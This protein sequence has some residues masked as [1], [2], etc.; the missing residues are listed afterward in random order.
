M[1]N[2]TFSR[3][4][5]SLHLKILAG[6]VILGMLI[7]GLV[8]AVWYEKRVFEEAEAEERSLL[9]QREA[10]GEAYRGLIAL[11]LDTD[12]AMLWDDS[13]M[14]AY[15]SRD[16]HTM[17]VMD[18]LKGYY[19]EPCQTARIDTI[20]R[21]LHEKRRL[22]GRMVELPSTAS[23]MDSLLAR[24]LPELERTASAQATTVTERTEPEKE[25]KQGG[26]LGLFRRKKKEAPTRTTTRVLT[27]PNT[28]HIAEMRRFED[29][30][31]TALEEQRQAY[32]RLSDSLEMRNRILTRN[33]SRLISEIGKEE[34]ERMERRHARVAELRE[35]AFALICAISAAG[36][37]CAVLL[38]AVV[39]RDIR[40]RTSERKQREGL[41][42]T[43]RRSIRENEELIRSRQRIMQ[44]VTHDL[45]SPLTAIRGNAELIL[46]EGG[47]CAA[48]RHA[49]H[50]RQSAERMGGLMEN[51]MEYYRI[52]NGKE[53]AKAKPFRLAGIAE[54]LE[55]EFEPRM[56]AKRLVFGVHCTADEVVTGDR[57]MILRI[58]SNLLSNALKFTRRG[59]VSLTT[60]YRE[61]RFT[62]TVDDTGTGIEKDRQEQIFKPFER[63]G[64]AATQDGFGLGL[65]IV[66][67]LTELMEGS[68]TVDS[69]PG[70]GSRFS[71][72][73]P[74]PLSEGTE[75]HDHAAPIAYGKL[76]GCSVLSI[77][78][79]EVMLG[80]MHD[81]FAQ[82]GLHSDT[83]K[84]MGG[85]TEKLRGNRY[86][87][88]TTDL[89][90]PDISGYGVLELLRTS[91]IGNSRTV[92]V[93]V[94]T[95]AG[96]I[97]KE[98]L[99]EAG[100]D[101]VLFKPFSTE[102]LL[103]AAE[104]CI[105]E[106]RT[107]H[108][109]LTPLFAYGNKR[110]RLE[111]LIRETEKEMDG[112]RESTYR[113]DYEE[114]DGWIHHIRCSWMLIRAEQPLQELYEALHENRTTEEIR[115]K[116]GNVLAQGGKIIRLAK[117]ELE[118][119]AWEE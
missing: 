62:I 71:V 16:S 78:N 85:L 28:R 35:R 87:L 51:L 45:R 31:H 76:A 17:E 43:L 68:I 79:D 2:N 109:D 94:V 96:S 8:T 99:E 42:E 32:Y 100:F 72:V 60:D 66:R 14:K 19:T 10:A 54:A 105:G 6:Y 70:K 30:M 95:A 84:D 56:A 11:F 37:L 1:S 26:L 22:I 81:M 108:I 7:L 49:E 90:M 48:T 29:E 50:I 88:L 59:S 77:D 9:M 5:K 23:R 73:L 40:R 93:L 13:D 119:T 64:N 107:R 80:M 98:E 53:T 41:I 111:S 104:Q 44:T 63:L 82:N 86:D 69:I 21:L 34:T 57:D 113:G 58:G 3:W 102:E 55:A 116:A 75:G 15:D 83:C 103:A 114:A 97:M 33:L 38:Y 36:I 65:A 112:I 106:N 52:D 110:E 117:K 74:L 24:R 12:R 46:R 39:R 92:P 118:E 47:R 101:G 20:V 27:V 61:G 91:D 115:E 89:K 25:R 18:R 4:R 67:S